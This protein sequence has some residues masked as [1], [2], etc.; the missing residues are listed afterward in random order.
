MARGVF[1]ELKLTSPPKG[2]IQHAWRT[3]RVF[4]EDPKSLATTSLQPY[5]ASKASTIHT[6]LLKW[7][8]GWPEDLLD[9][10]PFPTQPSLY[11]DR[12]EACWYLAG[13]LTLPHVVIDTPQISSANTHHQWLSI[14]DML[15]RLMILSDQRKLDTQPPDFDAKYQIILEL[16]AVCQTTSP[17][18]GLI[19]REPDSIRAGFED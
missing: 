3:K 2:I 11:Q 8:H 16:G 12:A 19:Y 14:H 10:E 15:T 9:Y 17:L 7:R 18:S 6:A 5:L 4:L 1:V 13:I